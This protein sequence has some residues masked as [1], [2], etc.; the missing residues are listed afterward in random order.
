MKSI[1]QETRFETER[2][3]LMIRGTIYR[4][5]QDR[6]PIAIISH[7]F[8]ANEKTTA[9][10]ARYFAE[11]GYVAF[12]YD[13][14]GGCVHGRSDGNTWDMSVLTEKEDLKAVIAYASG[15]P[16]TDEQEIL[17]AG[18]SQGGFVSALVA[19]ELQ[20]K[21]HKLILFYPALCIPDDARAGKMMTA[22]FDP[23]D[24]PEK[25]QCGPM[26]LGRRYPMD[27]MHMD[28]FA[29]I[30]A[31]RGP[32]LILHGTKDRIVN[33]SYAVRA[34]EAYQ[35]KTGAPRADVVMHLLEDA[36]HGFNKVENERAFFVIDQFLAGRSEVLAVD[37]K[38]TGREIEFTG[39]GA[40]TV[41]LPFVGTAESPY[42]LGRIEPGAA[43]VQQW[44]GK[45]PQH[46]EATYTI[47]GQDYTGADCFVK[48]VNSC[49]PDM[50]WKPVLT[51]DSEALSFLNGADCYV[52]LEHRKT[53][54]YVRI[55]T[56]V[57]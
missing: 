50:N 13:F 36:D 17:L 29:E 49:G 43:D 38:L 4:S 27:V 40:S 9:D 6:L 25:F 7:G 34:F 30:S 21:I 2:D 28:P 37:V 12:T 35:S 18:C 56:K 15:L 19:A 1:L 11:R 8:M 24:V 53:G 41:T 52:N 46:C 33:V 23:D 51:T 48:V 26:K 31:Y 47:T 39:K 45:K 44:Q 57:V 20:E 55:F 22:K 54:P 32:V 5:N 10:Y 14:C 42:F 3:G 16:F